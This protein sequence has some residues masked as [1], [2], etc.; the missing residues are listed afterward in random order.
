[1]PELFLMVLLLS[2]IPVGLAAYVLVA[3]PGGSR[4]MQQG[5]LL[6]V[7]AIAIRRHQTLPAVLDSYIKSVDGVHAF[8]LLPRIRFIRS[9]S[10]LSRSLFFVQLRGLSD[11]L[12]DGMSLPTAFAELPGLLP[13][14]V[15]AAIRIGQ[16]TG[17]LGEA[18]EEAATRQT[19][20][21]RADEATVE[22]FSFSVYALTVLLAIFVSLC[23]Q[24][25]YIV[26]RLAEVYRQ[27]G[28]ELPSISRLIFEPSS[29]W[30]VPLLVIV[31]IFT[32]PCLLLALLA[33][34]RFSD[35][36]SLRM[37]RLTR[38]WSRSRAV[39]MLRSLSLSLR[40]GAGL[41]RS[42]DIQIAT[43]TNADVVE[44]LGR[45]RETI[46]AGGNAWDAM[47]Q[48]QILTAAE[49]DVLDSAQRV[50]NLPWALAALAETCE[51]Q[52][53]RRAQWLFLSIRPVLIIFLGVIV[54]FIAVAFFLPLVELLVSNAG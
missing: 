2:V 38:W 48:Q 39:E 12:R 41:D 34:G 28:T 32:V 13:R 20:S 6:W 18:L 5:Q 1:M 26:P 43:A 47:Q 19:R 37:S 35:R 45:V 54:G 8:S 30:A 33:G 23:F 10:P 31:V 50:G 21:L 51:R 9:A 4:R 14:S 27:F 40:A 46:A 53:N 15:V 11:R 29:L 3:G 7:L 49:K 17:C 44:R 22:A 36:D 25:V 16:E 42:I 52:T 24:L